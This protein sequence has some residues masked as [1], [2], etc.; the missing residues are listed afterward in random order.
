M[1]KRQ[2]L[3]TT[4]PS[5]VC[6]ES[7]TS[8]ASS[9]YGCI[10]SSAINYDSLANVTND[11]CLYNVTFIVDMSEAN[12]YYDTLELNG[13]FNSWCGNCAQMEDSNNDSVWVI[14]IP[15]MNGD[16]EYKFSADNW[17]IQE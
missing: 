1:Y 4:N 14:T 7:C 17:S 11:S 8:C 13:T 3:N 2:N 15:L 9:I 16:Y 6:W 10:D 12:I 5:L